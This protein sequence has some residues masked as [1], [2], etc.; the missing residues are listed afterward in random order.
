VLFS[1]KPMKSLT[2]VPYTCSRFVI[3]ATTTLLVLG[4]AT[5]ETETPQQEAPVSAAA[6]NIPDPL[7]NDG[8]D[9]EEVVVVEE[10]YFDRGVRALAAR[11]YDQAATYFERHRDTEGSEAQ[12]E[13]DVGIAFVT[14]M[15]EASIA[16]D[17]S[18]ASGIDER[19]EVMILALAAVQIL[20]GRLEA[21]DALNKAISEDLEK[22]E[23]AL[24]R[25]RD[26]TLGQ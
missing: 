12:R 26:L 13:A 17:D 25:L 7:S 3:V 2:V 14:L 4:C 8:C 22:R 16:A 11:D 21:L 18:T 10:N 20:E 15:S 24:K 1:K 23:E 6:L 19:A 5:P 9:C